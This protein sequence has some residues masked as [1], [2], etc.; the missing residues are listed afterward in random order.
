M[1]QALTFLKWYM[2]C[3]ELEGDREMFR[4]I[5]LGMV[6]GFSMLIISCDQEDRTKADTTL[7][8]VGSKIEQGAEKVGESIDTAVSGIKASRSESKIEGMLHNIKGMENVKVDLTSG[9]DVTLLGSVDTE[10]RRSEA[11]RIVSQMEGVSTVV[12][13]IRVGSSVPSTGDTSLQ[14]DTSRTL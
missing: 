13:A 1:A 6:L 7:D 9:G 8:T 5:R 3:D 4:I 2:G 14:R 12:N 10:E 11:E